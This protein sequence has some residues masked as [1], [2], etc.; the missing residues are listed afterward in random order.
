MISFF[1]EDISFELGDAA[2]VE[3]WI[4]TTIQKEGKNLGEISFIFCSDSYLHQ[5]NLTHLNHD[6]YTDII[7]F[8]YNEEAVLNGDI[9]ISIDRVKENATTY[10][11]SFEN[12]LNRVMIHGVLHL[13]GYEDK[14][15]QEKA[16]MRAKEDFYLSLFPLRPL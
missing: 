10:N 8:N 5:I 1:S 3:H 11:V 7:T 16:A 12:E 2:S 13:A 4:Q 9:F 15:D 6:T 14:T